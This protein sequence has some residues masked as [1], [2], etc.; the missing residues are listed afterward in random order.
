M[1]GVNQ[2]F[3][4]FERKMR[5]DAQT[6]LA[7]EAFRRNFFAF[8]GGATGLIPENTIQPVDTP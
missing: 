3:A 5:D 7:M 2:L 1:I 4:P 8:V 6:D